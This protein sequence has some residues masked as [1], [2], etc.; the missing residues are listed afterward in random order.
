MESGG[1]EINELM[2]TNYL[3]KPYLFNSQYINYKDY[4]NIDF[5]SWLKSLSYGIYNYNSDVEV[6]SIDRSEENEL[7]NFSNSLVE[8]LDGSAYLID[9]DGNSTIDVISMLVIDQGFFDTD[10]SLFKIGDPLIPVQTED[11]VD[12]FSDQIEDSDQSDSIDDSSE[13]IE[14]SDQS[15]TSVEDEII[16]FQN[17]TIDNTSESNL[18]NLENSEN[19]NKKNKSSPNIPNL[20]SV[21]ENIFNFGNNKESNENLLNEN[22]RSDLEEP[23]DFKLKYKNKNLDFLNKGINKT[24]KNFSKLNNVLKRNIDQIKNIVD[25]FLEK[26][27]KNLVVILGFLTIPLLGERIFTP[28]AKKINLDYRLSLK[29]RSF[30]FSGNWIFASNKNDFYEIERGYNQITIKKTKT[31]NDLDIIPGFDLKNNSLLFKLLVSS[32]QPGRTI[33]S[34][35]NVLKKFSNIQRLDINWES[36]LQKEL[37]SYVDIKDK[38]N[39]F[40]V[41]ELESLFNESNAID[42][43]MSDIFMLAQMINCCE[44]LNIKNQFTS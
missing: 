38:H 8:E 7:I 1:V 37:I 35:E 32:E 26:D 19:L 42:P 5:D 43:A 23:Q 16:N 31:K 33:D 9:I 6:N 21:A 11:V 40:L 2:K 34:I 36:W 10:Q 20:Y 12:D 22:L 17:E 13:D 24:S 3:N 4:E 15:D 28:I 39:K 14:D 25:D 44:N 41:N 27:E 30:N 29:R 18:N